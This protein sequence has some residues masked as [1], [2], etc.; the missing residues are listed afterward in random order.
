MQRWS[1][2]GYRLAAACGISISI[3]LGP[4][5][6]QA[7]AD[8]GSTGALDPLEDVSA[9]SVVEV[10]DAEVAASQS[11]V[12]AVDITVTSDASGI[13]VQTA[14][15]SN[16]AVAG[17]AEP[18]TDTTAETAPVAPEEGVGAGAEV[19]TDTAEGA[20]DTTGNMTE[21]ILEAAADTTGSDETTQEAIEVVSDT[22]S[23]V[24]TVISDT[25]TA[26]SSSVDTVSE[27]TGTITDATSASSGT[28]D[29]S[30]STLEPSET[31]NGTTE[32]SYTNLEADGST[33]LFEG[34]YPAAATSTTSWRAPNQALRDGRLITPVENL[35]PC[36][37]S[38]SA[39]C[40]LAADVG[41]EDSLAEAIASIIRALAFTG[42]DLLFW[43]YVMVILTI[44]GTLSLLESRRRTPFQNLG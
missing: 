34:S 39:L 11:L 44:A 27:E 4:S 1:G 7:L 22:T 10:A 33:Q 17:A 40:T 28:V 15:D 12:A 30:L 18:V 16:E 36:T 2:R 32:S 21:P 42:A 19:T 29:A 5:T 35:G 24:P 25:T 9:G 3:F 38:A 6:L 13:S 31:S 41:G 37:G 14:D 23:G 26:L 8:E 43:L 20:A